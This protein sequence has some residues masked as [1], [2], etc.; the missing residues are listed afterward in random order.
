MAQQVGFSFELRN[1]CRAYAQLCEGDEK[2]LT[3]RMKAA[4]EAALSEAEGDVV[5]LTF[6]PLQRRIRMERTPWGRWRAR[7]AVMMDRDGHSHRDSLSGGA[8]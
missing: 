3:E 2:A 4:C 8:N 5:S 1:A 6:S 7:T